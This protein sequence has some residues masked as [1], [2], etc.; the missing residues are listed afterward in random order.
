MGFI[1]CSIL[2][3]LIAIPIYCYPRHLAGEKAQDDD[4]VHLTDTPDHTHDDGTVLLDQS[5]GVGHSGVSANK[6]IN[7]STEEGPIKQMKHVMSNATFVFVVLAG[8][9]DAFLI[10]GFTT[11]GPKYVETQF[12]LTAGMAGTLFGEYTR[13]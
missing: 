3:V 11:F 10:G 12:G 8:I 6:T 9:G 5:N 4:E 1:V 2:G 13:T 7:T